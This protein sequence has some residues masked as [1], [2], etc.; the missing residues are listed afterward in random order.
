MARLTEAGRQ[1]I[2]A[3]AFAT[4]KVIANQRRDSFPVRLAF[5][6]GG[7]LRVD[8]LTPFGTAAYSIL[9]DGLEATVLDHLGGTWWKGET[10]ALSALVPLFGIG[11]TSADI[12]RLLVGIPPEDGADTDGVVERQGV[13]FRSEVGAEG[14]ATVSVAGQSS[15][16]LL[17]RYLPP[18]FPPVSIRVEGGDGGE[19][20]SF[21]MEVRY[22]ELEPWDG[23][24]RDA[25]VRALRCCQLP[26]K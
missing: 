24:V 11:M 1:G 8:V 21:E 17:F 13:T 25:D 15:A 12:A 10:S 6:S 26:G 22:L 2:G 5:D 4:V 7:R 18:A 14:L 3:K 19:K 16:S 20:S 23:R 9:A